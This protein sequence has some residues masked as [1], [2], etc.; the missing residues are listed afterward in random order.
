[1]LYPTELQA[2]VGI[3]AS[4]VA[5]FKRHRCAVIEIVTVGL[6][7]NLPEVARADEVVVVEHRPGLVAAMVMT[8]RS[9]TPALTMFRTAVRRGSC[10]PATPACSKQKGY[11]QSSG[12]T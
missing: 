1:M 7:R 11:G 3:L 9:G 10:R 6:A 8:T 5:G 4:C 2:R 12:R